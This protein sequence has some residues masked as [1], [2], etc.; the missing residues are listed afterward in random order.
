[1]GP[2]LTQLASSFLTLS[3]PLVLFLLQN[4][5]TVVLRPTKLKQTVIRSEDL[6]IF[7]H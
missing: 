3:F 4:S 2:V 1:M 6:V 5:L 7:I